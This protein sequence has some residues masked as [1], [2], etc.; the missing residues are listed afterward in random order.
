MSE[1]MST[2]TF[3]E[4]GP[5]EVLTVSQRPMPVPG[6][7]EVVIRVAASTVN[8]TDLMMRSGLQAALMTALT[9]PYVAG[10]E[11][12]GRIHALGE[13]TTGLRHGQPVIGVV[14][15][16]RPDGG[17]H[18][19][20]L[21]V[22]ARSVAPLAPGIDL[23]GAA[24]VPMNA[25]T[26]HM[27]LE[28]LGLKQGQSVLI[29]GGAGMLGGY[30]I[31]LARLAGLIVVANSATEDWPF[32]GGLGADILV[33]R[34]EGM[35][36]G[37]LA[38]L[39]LGVDGLIDGALIGNRV[40]HL[41]REGGV[42]VSLRMSHPINDPRLKTTYVSVTEG[43]ER[44][45]VLHSIARHLGEGKLT[46]RLAGCFPYRQAA[47]A[48]RKAEEGGFRGRLVLIFDDAGAS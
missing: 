38:R 5:P 27:A 36:Q 20:Y 14:N 45:D 1:M 40:S 17:A 46:P 34:D 19:E 29:T 39:P 9:P 18:S 43:M 12:S 3:A 33:P 47:E 26:A 11:F 16:R 28:L 24:T 7:E 32:L 23:I 22:P 13:G 41:V 10:M 31:Q 37:V 30:A 44:T 35:A 15:P 6:P 2:V 42:A 21:R 48:H 4:F 8:P 25:L